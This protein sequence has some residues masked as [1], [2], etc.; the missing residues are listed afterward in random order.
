MANE[1][2]LTSISSI[3][4]K[5]IK[6]EIYAKNNEEYGYLLK[7]TDLGQDILVIEDSYGHPS[8]EPEHFVLNNI[9]GDDGIYHYGT[10]Y[11][12]DNDL[13]YKEWLVDTYDPN[14]R[15]TID[16]EIYY[17]IDSNNYPIGGGSNLTAGT[18]LVIDSITNTISVNTNGT[19]A[20]SANMSFVAGS[21]TSADGIGAIAGGTYSYA[22]GKAAFAIGTSASAIGRG[23]FAAGTLFH[24]AATVLLGALASGDG[25]VAIG[26]GT[27]AIAAGAYAEGEGT[28]ASGDDS[29]AE[30]FWTKAYKKCAHAEGN[31][32]HAVDLYSHAE[33]S[34]TT[35]YGQ[36]SHAEGSGTSAVGDCSHAEGSGTSAVGSASHA[37]GYQ[38]SAIG[39]YSH[40]EGGNTRASGNYSHAECASTSAFT[41]YSHAEGNQTLASGLYGCHAEGLHTSAIG[42]N[43]HA[44]GYSAL[45]S[46]NGSHAEGGETSAVGQHSHAE[47]EHTIASG[48]YSHAG[49]YYTTANDSCMTVIGRYNNT[50]ESAVFVIGN[51][52]PSPNGRTDAFIVDWDGNISGSNSMI[53]NSSTSGGDEYKGITFKTGPAIGDMLWDYNGALLFTKNHLPSTTSKPD[54]SHKVFYSDVGEIN[55]GYYL[56]TQGK[57]GQCRQI[58]P[59]SYVS[60]ASQGAP[61]SFN[62]NAL[63]QFNATNNAY[64]VLTNNMISYIPYKI[65]GKAVVKNDSNTTITVY[66][67]KGENFT[68]GP[69]ATFTAD[70]NDHRAPVMI[71][72]INTTTMLYSW[73]Y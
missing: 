58:M 55:N 27:S 44:E 54:D 50:T 53:L 7:S 3:G 38:T 35:A 32:T 29:H 16:D 57:L 72:K 34:F 45:A 12:N 66:T 4:G 52:T 14:K 48:N 20:D 9:N 18:D 2:V 26:M 43:S 68:L 67:T 11:S 63:E 49:G 41:N 13:Y 46:G 6:T 5:P 24:P 17:I 31:K 42:N 30:G 73:G 36:G 59:I 10:V 69:N 21:G 19:V 56:I 8:F 47:G 39:Y 37:E 64:Q 60:A 15:I 40:A 62:Y 1:N 22:S 61:A 23:A 28:I 33:G 71:A 70:N 65:Y 25:A 51:G